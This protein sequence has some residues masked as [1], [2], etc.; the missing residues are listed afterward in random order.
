MR[1]QELSDSSRAVH[2]RRPS[3]LDPRAAGVWGAAAGRAAAIALCVCAAFAIAAGAAYASGPMLRLLSNGKPV[4]SGQRTAVIDQIAFPGFTC[5][6]FNGAMH[7]GSNPARVLKF[8]PGEEVGGE[9]FNS[10][11]TGHG[12]P[13]GIG[14][15]GKPAKLHLVTVSSE[16]VTQSFVPGVVF[17]DEETGCIWELHKLAGPLPSSGD[18]ELVHVSGSLRLHTRVSARTCPRT[19]EAAGTATIQASPE[20]APPGSYEVERVP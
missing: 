3:Q 17:D 14:T 8:I 20:G 12:Q 4:P 11:A 1:V 10:C 18:L 5:E 13:V 6:G 7:S 19:A 2:A 16:T 15:E 9:A